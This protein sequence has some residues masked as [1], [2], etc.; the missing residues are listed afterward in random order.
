MTTTIICTYHNFLNLSTLLPDAGLPL[1][2]VVGLAVGI[3]LLTAAVTTV[4]VVLCVVICRLRRSKLGLER[5]LT[6]RV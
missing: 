5:R 4:V 2:A 3:P 6:E 1:P